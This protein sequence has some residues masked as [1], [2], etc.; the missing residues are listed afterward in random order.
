MIVGLGVDLVPVSRVKAARSRRFDERIFT[1]AELNYARQH[2]DAD[3]RLA[4]R[5]AAKE[6]VLKVLGTG[7][8]KGISWRDVETVNDRAGR[9]VLCLKGKAATRAR[10]LGI[11]R[12]HLSIAHA[13]G[14]A[15][16]AAIAEG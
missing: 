9:P 7:W 13:G 1:P 2:A 5:F 3:E 14:N 4:G 10:S 16:A 8:A 6:A 12:W 11:T 15:L